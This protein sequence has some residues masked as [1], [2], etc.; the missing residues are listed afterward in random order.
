MA[1]TTPFP[2]LIIVH[3]TTACSKPQDGLPTY[4]EQIDCSQDRGRQVYIHT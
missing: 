1:V 3:F 4:M 2:I